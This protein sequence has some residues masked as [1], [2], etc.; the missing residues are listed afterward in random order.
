[1]NIKTIEISI[2]LCM[3]KFLRKCVTEDNLNE[4]YTD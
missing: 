3:F 2:I 1:M 4:K